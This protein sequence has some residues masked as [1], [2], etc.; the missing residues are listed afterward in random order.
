MGG[1]SII[2]FQLSLEFEN[3]NEFNPASRQ[4]SAIEWSLQV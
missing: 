2:E 4:N 3:S 1:S